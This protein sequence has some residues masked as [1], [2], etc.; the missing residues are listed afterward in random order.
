MAGT[1]EWHGN[2]QPG[3]LQVLSAHP[4]HRLHSQLNHTSLREK[5][6]VAAVEPLTLHPLDAQARN[7]AD[8]DVVVWIARGQ[9][10]RCRG[11]GRYSSRGYLFT[12]RGLA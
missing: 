7:I 6:A 9:A 2:A 3:Q 11:D 5:Y 10:G 1:D 12:R 8:G 4:A